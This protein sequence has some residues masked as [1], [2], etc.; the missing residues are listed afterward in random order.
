MEGW[1]RK[2]WVQ[3]LAVLL[4]VVIA[5]GWEFGVKGTR[6]KN[7]EWRGTIDE[8]FRKREW[9][10]G[11]KKFNKPEYHYYDHYWRVRED[12]GTIRTVE[13]HHSLWSRGK[14]GDPVEKVTGERWPRLATP[15]G[16]QDREALDLLF[17]TFTE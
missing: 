10:A 5:L 11:L 14:V 4:T 13:V 1:W 6:A 7:Q 8:T 9:L 2:R 16:R 12:G 17:N 15:Q 3:L